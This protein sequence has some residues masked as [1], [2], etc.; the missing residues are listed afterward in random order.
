M[1]SVIA[2]IRCAEERERGER[3]SDH[4]TVNGEKL[5]MSVTSAESTE[6]ENATERFLV[7]TSRRHQD[8]QGRYCDTD[9]E[10][11]QRFCTAHTSGA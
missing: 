4:Q 10:E 8:R 5:F 11:A 9:S 7:T 1:A 6:V 2:H 3:A